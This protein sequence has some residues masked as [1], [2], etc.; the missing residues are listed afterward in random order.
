MAPGYVY[1]LFNSAAPETVKVGR[2]YKQ[3]EVRAGEISAATGV[4]GKWHAI[5]YRQFSDCDAAERIAHAKLDVR[6]SR[7]RHRTELF[8]VS[9]KVAI[10][11]IMTIPEMAMS[12][13]PS[14][15]DDNDPILD[16][17]S[18]A[19]RLLAAGD[20]FLFGL[21]DELEDVEAAVD[22][23][24][25][26]A[27]IGS[28]KAHERLGQIWLRGP[29]GRKPD[30]D[31][32]LEAFKDAERL[33]STTSLLW[34]S[35]AWLK[36]R[37]SENAR[38]CITRYFVIL[39][40][41]A[42]QEELLVALLEFLK[43]EVL[44]RQ[45]D[46]AAMP[47]LSRYRDRLLALLAD[48]TEQKAFPS[49]EANRLRQLILSGR[50]PLIAVSERCEKQILDCLNTLRDRLENAESVASFEREFKLKVLVPR[51][52]DKKAPYRHYGSAEPA[53][54]GS[55]GQLFN[56]LELVASK[57]RKTPLPIRNV[58]SFGTKLKDAL[59]YLRDQG[60]S[61]DAKFSQGGKFYQVMWVGEIACSD[62]RA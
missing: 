55:P 3:P 34:M 2:T 15:P 8:E 24:E 48:E 4:L 40:T 27:K 52:F 7:H 42:E 32:A 6:G 13:Q 57:Y 59:E 61:I 25:K 51:R 58:Y 29:S 10:D 16:T 20:R 37:H 60:W 39:S 41:A 31:K 35:R 9:P 36:K 33:G 14:L 47:D 11:C 17:A 38:K 54:R 53:F 5:Y 46:L 62:R 44:T 22:R 23:Y 43:D 18:D 50:A 21:D 1:V 12:A 28:A 45:I 56:A 26:A 19:D 49:E 30:P